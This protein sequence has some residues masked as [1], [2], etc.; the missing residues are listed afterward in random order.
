QIVMS[1]RGAIP[2]ELA[3]N[4]IGRL[5]KALANFIFVP[6]YVYWLGAESYGVVAFAMTI[7]AAAT[8]LDFGLSTTVSRELARRTA[9]ANSKDDVRSLVRT[10]EVIYWG[11]GLVLGL[12]V[13]VGA[14]PIS[15]DWLTTKT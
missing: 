1:T 14:G 3:A 13:F 12:L 6:L 8:L 11:T 15:S 5:W 4:Y 7:Q 10:L 2:L 9:L